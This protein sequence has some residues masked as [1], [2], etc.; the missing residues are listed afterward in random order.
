M[1]KGA[2]EQIQTTAVAA[3][4]AKTL[5]LVDNPIAILPKDFVIHNLEP[6]QISRNRYRGLFATT[7]LTDFATYTNVWDADA[8]YID[9]ECM[10]AVSILNQGT[11]DAPGHCDHRASLTL[12]RSAPYRALIKINSERLTQRALA[13]WLEEWRDCLQH[14]E[15]QVKQM[16]AAVRRLT[17]TAKAEQ[18]RA[19]GNFCTSKA[20]LESIDAKGADAE[21]PQLIAFNCIPYESLSEHTFIMR[22]SLI[23]GDSAPL[24]C[25]RILQ[26]EAAIEQIAQ[27]FKDTLRDLISGEKT[28]IYIGRFEP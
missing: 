14:D 17:I 9:A 16:I 19:E 6:Y 12:Q 3:T 2:I 28:D 27:D 18:T 23:T 10:T 8:C 21:L 24:L 7:S 13:E 11:Q 20:A 22:L 25:V 26:H 5:P 4:L 1:D 15:Q